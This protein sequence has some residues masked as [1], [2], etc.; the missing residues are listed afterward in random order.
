MD[1][2]EENDEIREWRKLSMAE[3]WQCQAP[4]WETYLTLGGSL[5]PE[6]DRQSPFFAAYDWGQVSARRRS[7]VHLVRR[8]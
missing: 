4:L 7:G 1:W 3:R 5:E 2:R 6:P 8:F